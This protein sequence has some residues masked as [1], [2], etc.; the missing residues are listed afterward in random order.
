MDGTESRDDLDRAL[1]WD[2]ILHEGGMDAGDL[3]HHTKLGIKRVNHLLNHEWFVKLS[4]MV[5]IAA[6]DGRRLKPLI[7]RA[8]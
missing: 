1:I 5:Y 4:G 8:G 7:A 3:A 6:S 2:A